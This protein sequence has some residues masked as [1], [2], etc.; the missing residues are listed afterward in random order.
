M[1]GIMTDING[2]SSIP[3][4]SAIGECASV[5]LHG[6]NRLAS[7]SLLQAGVMAL[8]TVAYLIDSKQLSAPICA[9]S[10]TK[11]Q[12]T[13]PYLIPANL[14]KLK[15]K[16]YNYAGLVK[17]EFR[18]KEML[19]Y[20]ST[21]A[22]PGIIANSQQAQAAN[23]HLLACLVSQSALLRRESRGSHYRSDFQE[24][25]DHLFAKRLS[26]R[27]SQQESQPKTQYETQY[28]WLSH[29]QSTPALSAMPKLVSQSK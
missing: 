5:G 26:V 20:L 16:M 10:K 9:L 1:G 28:E 27:L 3:G 6:A 24:T 2:M 11:S 19:S 15:T 4:L 18:L 25:N 29:T 17:D 8:K 13:S 23:L 21:S 14:T 12:L 7:N 22:H